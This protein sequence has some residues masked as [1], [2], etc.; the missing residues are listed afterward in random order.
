MAVFLAGYFAPWTVLGVLAIILHR[1]LWAHPHA[2]AAVAFALAAG[3]ALLPLRRRAMVACHRVI[4][5][6]PSGWRADRDCLRYGL[7]IGVACVTTCWL[8]MLGCALT[9]HALPAMVAGAAIAARER[10]S[11][12]PPLR[13]VAAAIAALAVSYGLPEHS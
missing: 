11:F 13:T 1:L 10:R 12:R 2:T 7:S 6:A 5:L 3:W 8:L 4:P 9:G